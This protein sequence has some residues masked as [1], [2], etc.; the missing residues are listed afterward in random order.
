[1][2]LLTLHNPIN[3]AAPSKMGQGVYDRVP[4]AGIGN[5]RW[6]EA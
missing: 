2:T 6:L 4:F 3:S 5:G 1:M